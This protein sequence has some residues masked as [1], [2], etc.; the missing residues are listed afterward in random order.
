MIALHLMPLILLLLVLCYLTD[1]LDG[2]DLDF[3]T[4][5]EENMSLA[6]ASFDLFEGEKL[7]LGNL[8]SG[9]RSRSGTEDF[10][11]ANQMFFAGV[12]LKLLFVINV[13]TIPCS[14]NPNNRLDRY[15]LQGAWKR[16]LRPQGERGFDYILWR[17]AERPVEGPQKGVVTRGFQGK[18]TVLTYELNIEIFTEARH[19]H[20]H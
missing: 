20:S 1:I 15:G 2:L 8:N 6:N 19:R 17:C 18:L 4:V 10:F 5:D 12:L 11:A 9:R 13:L 7:N 3:L 16:D 14:P